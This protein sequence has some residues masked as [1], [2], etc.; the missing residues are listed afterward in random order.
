MSLSQ[1]C[2]CT[3]HT[4]P[5]SWRSVHDYVDPEDLHGVERVGETKKSGESDESE[6][7][8]APGRRE[9]WLNVK[10]LKLALSDLRAELKPYKVLNVVVDHLAFFNGRPGTNWRE[11]QKE[12]GRNGGEREE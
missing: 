1:T 3:K 9:M 4:V 12:R 2:T 10:S 6:G 11:G 5:L 7:G 8:Y